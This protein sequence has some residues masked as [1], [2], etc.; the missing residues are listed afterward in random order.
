MATIKPPA[1]NSSSKFTPFNLTLANGATTTGISHIPIPDPSHTKSPPLIIGI[2]GGTCTAYNFDINPSHTASLA[3]SALGVPFVAFSR[4]SYLDSTPTPIPAESSFHRETGKWEHE[5]IIPALW[6]KFGKPNGCSGI[7]L[8]CHSMGV[9][10]A[11]I[12]ASLWAKDASPKYPLAGL[13][14]SGWGTTPKTRESM[15]Q[16]LPPV[17]AEGK[18][19]LTPLKK[20]VMLSE[21]EYDGF[22]PEVVPLVLVQDVPITIDEFTDGRQWL[23]YGREHAKDVNVPM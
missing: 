22:S 19:S 10:G 18:I 23:D 13:I 14:L 9:P 16:Q 11:I 4:P 1:T 12:A 7:V 2:H 8:S 15:Q 6:E 20:L 21:D 17:S 3:S 5:F